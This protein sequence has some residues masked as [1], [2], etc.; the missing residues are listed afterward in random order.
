MLNVWSHRHQLDRMQKCRSPQCN[1]RP[2]R[3]K[4]IQ[5]TIVEYSIR[6]LR[7]ENDVSHLWDSSASSQAGQ[8]TKFQQKGKV[9]KPST[10]KRKTSRLFS[11]SKHGNKECPRNK[12]SNAQ[13][14][15][16]E[17]SYDLRFPSLP[18]HE[19]PHVISRNEGRLLRPT[20]IKMQFII[21]KPRLK[22]KTRKL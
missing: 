13:N 22:G 12:N 3:C 11:S 16:A 4:T 7:N 15:S 14:P 21:S 1:G 6:H 18:E 20:L 19:K 2:P 10:H 9:L 5:R 17:T 8:Q